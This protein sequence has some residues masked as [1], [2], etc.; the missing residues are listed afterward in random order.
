MYFKMRQSAQA[1]QTDSPGLPF[2]SGNAIPSSGTQLSCGHAKRIAWRSRAYCWMLVQMQTFRMMRAKRLL[3]AKN[4]GIW[5][6][7]TILVPKM[8]IM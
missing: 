4:D 5:G 8:A 2:E 3:E 7:F 6:L 1:K